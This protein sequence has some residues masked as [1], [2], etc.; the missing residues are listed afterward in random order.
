MN[1]NQRLC[2]SRVNVHSLREHLAFEMIEEERIKK[3]LIDEE[4]L[5][6]SPRK[7]LNKTMVLSQHR[8]DIRDLVCFFFFFFFLFSICS[9]STIIDVV[10]RLNLLVKVFDIIQL[11]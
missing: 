7:R 1:M 11:Y 10:F 2:H 5:P 9:I 4:N 6:K 3:G 8:P